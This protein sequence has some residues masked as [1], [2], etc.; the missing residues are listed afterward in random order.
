MANNNYK[1]EKRQKDLA[2]KKKQDEKRLKK[3]NRA[4]GINKED[5]ESTGE[6]DTNEVLENAEHT[7]KENQSVEVRPG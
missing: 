7:A 1:F 4:T 3:L 5:S 6:N 2:K